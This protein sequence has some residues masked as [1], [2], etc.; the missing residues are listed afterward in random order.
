MNSTSK[1][2]NSKHHAL[3]TL[4]CSF[5]RKE[6]LQFC[7]KPPLLQRVN[8]IQTIALDC[9]QIFY[10][11]TY[12]HPIPCFLPTVQFPIHTDN[13]H[14]SFNLLLQ[15]LHL[16]LGKEGVSFPFPQHPTPF[17]EEVC[18]HSINYVVHLSVFNKLFY[19]FKSPIKMDITCRSSI[20]ICDL[21]HWATSYSK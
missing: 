10:P 15:I 3:P 21:R 5:L 17:P 19:N 18:S 13:Y 8:H 11:C 12:N 20:P 9:N 4:L 6:S 16:C 7:P 1:P 2:T 14:H